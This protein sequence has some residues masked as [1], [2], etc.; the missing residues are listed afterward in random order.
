MRIA[1]PPLHLAEVGVDHGLEDH[2]A[3]AHL[4]GAAAELKTEAAAIAGFSAQHSSGPGASRIATLA[5]ESGLREIESMPIET[6]Y[7]AKSG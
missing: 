5:S 6:R 2:E 7:S 3:F 1:R 4:A